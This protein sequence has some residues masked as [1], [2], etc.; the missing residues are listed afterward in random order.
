MSFSHGSESSFAFDL[1]R[2]C[3]KSVCPSPPQPLEEVEQLFAKK[4]E[5]SLSA[6]PQK[7]KRLKCA[8]N[9]KAGVNGSQLLRDLKVEK[10]NAN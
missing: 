7:Q 3:W 9:G 5:N 10:G 4:K 1:T 8:G 6:S 2:T